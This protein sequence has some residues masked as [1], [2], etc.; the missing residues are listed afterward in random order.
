MY[1]FIYN[2]TPSIKTRAIIPLDRLSLLTKNPTRRIPKA[3]H[4]SLQ[5]YYHG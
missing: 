4:I 3:W 2:T 5:T 1:E